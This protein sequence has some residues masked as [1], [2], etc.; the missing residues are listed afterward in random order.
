[1]KDVQLGSFDE[2]ADYVLAV[3]DA[4]QLHQFIL[5]GYSLGGA[6]GIEIAARVPERLVR[7]VAIAPPVAAGYELLY[8]DMFVDLSS[9][10]TS[11]EVARRTFAWETVDEMED[12]WALMGFPKGSLPRFFLRMLAYRRATTYAPGHW[13][14]FIKNFGGSMLDAQIVPLT[15]EQWTGLRRFAADSRELVIVG[16]HDRVLP[17]EDGGSREGGASGHRLRA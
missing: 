7:L 4:L 5:V 8:P 1:M 14:K 10:D 3:L 6:T 15:T 11:P 12:C 16:D 9:I 2:G 17:E 13:L